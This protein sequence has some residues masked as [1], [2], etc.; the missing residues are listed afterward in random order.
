MDV[1]E[2]PRLRRALEVVGLPAALLAVQAVL[3]PMPAGVYVQG[4]TL[5]LL[6]AVVSVGLCLLYRTNR[7]ISFAQSALGLVPTVVAVDLVVYSGWGFVQAGLAGAA[8]ATV[9]GA[10][11]HVLLIRRFAHASRLVLTVATIGVAQA[12]LAVSLEVPR[13]WGKDT[14]AEQI[15]TG[16]DVDIAI[17]PL[18]FHAEHLLAWVVAPTVLALVAALLLRTRTGAAVRAAA[19]RPDRAALLGIPVDRIQLLVWAGATLL[20]FV[21]VFLRVAITGLPFASTESFT[22]LLAALAALTL[23]RFTDL[24]RVAAASIALGVVEQAI[25]WNHPEDPDLYGVVLAVVIAVGLAL[26]A[27]PR[28]RLDRDTTTA[29]LE[30]GPARLPAAL[31]RR[32]GVRVTRWAAGLGLLVAAVELPSHL[33]SGDQLKAAT[34]I[35]FAIVGVSLVVLTGWAGQVSLG[36][37]GFVAVGAAVGAWT[38][39]T[40]DQDLAVGLLAA[41]GAGGVTALVVGLPALRLRGLALAVVTLAF[42]VATASYLLAPDDAGWIPD[43]RVARGQVLG[44]DLASERRMYQLCLAVLVGVLWAAHAVRTSR[45]GRAMVAQ[46]DNELAAEARGTSTARTRLTAFALSGTIAAT[47]GCLLVHLLQSYPDQL[48]TPD[49]SISTFGATVVGGIGSPAGA[50]LG[51]LL[52]VGSGWFLGDTARVLSTAIGLLLVLVLVPS[53]IT[54]ALG[55]LRDRLLGALPGTASRHQ[56]LAVDDPDAPPRT[57]LAP[58]APAPDDGDDAVP[59]LRVRGLRV[60]IG[61]TPIV[62]DVSFDLAPGQTLA[63]LGTNGA[64]KSTV[65]NAISGLLPTAAGSVEHDGTAIT[66][67]RPHRIAARGVVQA[68]GGRGVFPSLTVAEHLT[69]A[70]WGRPRRDRGVQERTAA[71]LEAFPALAARRT[72]HAADLSG[73]EQ[74]MLVLA[75]ASIAAPSVLL[76]DELGLGLAPIVVGQLVGFLDRMRASGTSLVVV[77]QSPVAALALTDTA[78]FLEQGRIVLAGSVTDVLDRPDVARSVYLASAAGPT[79]ERPHHPEPVDPPSTTRPPALAAHGVSVRYGGVHAVTDV[80]LD[81]A[82]GEVVGLIGPNGAGKSTLLDVL[83]GLVPHAVGQVLVD[84]RDITTTPF[85]RRASLGLGRSFQDARLFPSLTVE[86]VLAVACDRSLAAPGVTDAVWRTPAQ[87]RGEAAVRDRVDELVDRLALDDLRGVRT[88]ELSTGQRRIVDL[89]ALLADQPDIV[90]LDEPSSGLA[91]PEVEALGRLLR[92][93]H[94]DLALTMVVVE[95]D[96]PLISSTATR[97][98]VLDQGRTIADGSPATVLDDDRVIASYL[99]R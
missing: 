73:G 6:G 61:S 20:S 68:P 1:T 24:A 99:G 36:Q 15:T 55:A 59:A 62:D 46:R 81:V 8:L 91:Q 53:G 43:A 12:C 39:Q 71:A 13:L 45:P 86:E 11:L 93:L 29:W 96:I 3:L 66:G 78:V 25:T 79:D 4:L 16:W 51:A 56:P 77:E 92:R 54:G 28:T 41:A 58:P 19:D 42:N 14:R 82:S 47:A 60:R 70:G 95:H 52:F 30:G 75:M 17:D 9:L 31:A 76:I 44:I 84:G 67:R 90:L 72:A 65:L 38:T 80:D 69:L 49:R 74:Q 37:M 23:G 50:V 40:H 57:A 34:V 85:H 87:R 83:S 63:L 18:L 64:G 2:T 32:P 94:R 7:I 22:A 10:A 98:V 97:L 33:G 5:G 26:A 21:G 89:A 88:G 35:V 48:L 27:R